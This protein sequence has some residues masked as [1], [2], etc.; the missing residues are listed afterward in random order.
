VELG[1]LEWRGRPAVD[2]AALEQVARGRL[3]P[4]VYDYVAGGADSE[5]TLADNLAAWDRVRLRPRVLR[6]VRRVDTA[7]TLLGV[8]LPAPIL[9]AP[10]GYHELV[11][12]QAEEATAAGA[13][14]AGSLMVVSTQANRSVEQVAAA[15]PGAPRWFQVYVHVDHGF[16]EEVVGRAAA[17]GYSALVLTADLPVL[18]NRLRDLRNRLRFPPGMVLGNAVERFGA[19]GEDVVAHAS[20]FE[21]GLEPAN[22]A[23]L[24]R[25]SGLPVL[26]KG[27]LR[28]DDAEEFVAAGAAGIMVSNHGGRQLDSALAAADAL[29][30]VVAA[31]AG[32]VPVLVDGGVRRGTDVVKALCLGAR[33]VLVGRP[34]LWGLAAAGA[35]GVRQVLAGL[36][37]ELVRGM[38]LCGA[39][40]LAELTPDLVTP[41]G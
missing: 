14:A 10:T 35:E 39:T 26:V 37:E 13:A 38:A 12:P 4:A 19:T 11:H 2:L 40:S 9:V 27:V 41:P 6:D 15:A 23:W 30:E 29:P 33:G 5:L 17:A 31:V 16:T 18:G 1:D 8:P 32:R 36:H 25:H 34:V 3:D 21:A 28:G 24:G 7:T 20:Q 22:I